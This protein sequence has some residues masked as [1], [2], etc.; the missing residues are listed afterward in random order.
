MCELLITLAT[1]WLG[2]T[3]SLLEAFFRELVPFT[4]AASQYAD[5]CRLL[6]PQLQNNKF[7]GASLMTEQLEYVTST[8]TYCCNNLTAAIHNLSPFRDM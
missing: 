1:F 4:K 6:I 7:L 5:S 3:R 8:M 2:A